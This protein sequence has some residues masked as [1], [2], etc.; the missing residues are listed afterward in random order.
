MNDYVCLARRFPAVGIEG[1]L[2]IPVSN[3]SEIDEY[4]EALP[5]PVDD[6]KVKFVRLTSIPEKSKNH[7]KVND[8]VVKYDGLS[9]RFL[10]ILRP[11]ETAYYNTGYQSGDIDWDLAEEARKQSFET[12]DWA[13]TNDKHQVAVCDPDG[14]LAV[15]RGSNGTARTLFRYAYAV[16]LDN[17][18]DKERITLN[19]YKQYTTLPSDK[20]R[21]AWSTFKFMHF[22]IMENG[23]VVENLRLHDFKKKLRKHHASIQKVPKPELGPY[24]RLHTRRNN[25]RTQEFW[26]R[27]RNEY[28]ND[29]DSIPRPLSFVASKHEVRWVRVD[30]S[31]IEEIFK[32]VQWD[33]WDDSCDPFHFSTF[34]NKKM[35][36]WN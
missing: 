26:K 18:R 5:V 28:L 30:L 13:L 6:A 10:D 20:P 17:D 16:Y 9:E 8:V 15:L 21:W 24:L 14:R 2:G 35:A 12:G 32:C 23:P 36:K 4:L 34:R 22:L 27:C 31:E 1:V 11:V 3:P 19:P 33:E 25:R 29:P 7:L